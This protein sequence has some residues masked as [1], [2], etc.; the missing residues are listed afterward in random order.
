MLRA[1]THTAAHAGFATSAAL[2]QGRTLQHP[3]WPASAPHPAD[4]LAQ[5]LHGVGHELATGRRPALGRIGCELQ[6]RP[7]HQHIVPKSINGLGLRV[8]Q[9]RLQAGAAWGQRSRA[10]RERGSKLA[11]MT[12]GG[13]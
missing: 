7:E 4:A 9:R 3:S 8:R 2:R 10:Q 12:Q 13:W 11:G 5:Q 1:D 6:V